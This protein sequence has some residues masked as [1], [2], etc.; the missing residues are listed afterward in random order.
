MAWSAIARAAGP[1]LDE[2]RSALLPFVPGQ[3]TLPPLG[4]RFGAFLLDYLILFVAISIS[5]PILLHVC[6]LN[7]M[8]PTPSAAKSALQLCVTVVWWMLY[9]GVLECIGDCSLG[10]RL[11]GLR[12]RSA[13]GNARP[14]PVR[15]ALRLVC[16]FVFTTFT[17]FTVFP[18]PWVVQDMPKPQADMAQ[19]ALGLTAMLTGAAGIGLLLCTMRQRNGYRGLHEFL[20]GTR[21]VQLPTRET[22]RQVKA[23]KFGEGL[24]RPAGLPERIGGYA[25]RGAFRWGPEI[26]LLLGDDAGLQRQVVICLRPATEPPLASVRREQTRPT[27]LR[28]LA[29]GQHEDQ[30]WDAF[31]APAGRSL[32]DLAAEQ[33]GLPWPEV[34]VIV[35]QLTEELM[36]ADYEGTLPDSLGADQIRVQSSGSIQL[37]DWPLRDRN[38]TPRQEDG[39]QSP[40]RETVAFIGEVAMLSLEG[41]PWQPPAKKGRKHFRHRPVPVH[42][43][44]LLARLLGFDR[45]FNA[46]DEFKRELAESHDLPAEVTRARRAGQLATMAAMLVLCMSCCMFPAGVAPDFSF[47]MTSMVQ[48]ELGKQLIQDV[49]V[50]TWREFA[51]SAVNPDPLLRLRGI[52]QLEA[53]LRLRDELKEKLQRAQDEREARFKSMSWIMRQYCEATEKSF[54]DQKAAQPANFPTN[55]GNSTWFRQQSQSQ[56]AFENPTRVAPWAFAGWCTFVIAIWPILWVLWA[57]VW[58]GGLSYRWLGLALARSNG[59]KG[60][61]WQ[62]ALRALLVWTPLVALWTGSVWLDMWYWPT[63]PLGDPDSWVPL[64]TWGMWWGGLA[65]MPIF[66]CLAITFPRRC[67]HD[68]LAG[69]YVVPR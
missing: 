32:P 1:T 10:K 41:K 42:A 46:V 18:L 28:W 47:M 21:V 49:E 68:W 54:Q 50:G 45:R 39:E 59:R 12:I 11:V 60:A 40:G 3:Q 67:V 25:I 34:R 55:P 23:E 15:A 7:L 61:R 30:Q 31:L 57:F 24:L 19:M 64:L 51:A 20:S 48:T 62:C 36:D 9:F 2:F 4:A 44:D 26:K 56:L 53:D 14:G 33:G 22:R 35:E 5:S 38:E 69:T 8:D 63:F 27:R 52:A 13:T 17:Q 29:S 66:A 65:L 43:D 58:R 37:L 16:F 6:G